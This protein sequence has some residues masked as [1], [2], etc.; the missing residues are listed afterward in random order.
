MKKGII[1][2]LLMAGTLLFANGAEESPAGEE[3]LKIGISQ[4][5]Q[6]PALDAVYQGIVDEMA[7]LGYEDVV[8]DYQ[9]SNADV[10]TA[11]Q[12]ANLYQSKKMDMVVGIA[13]PNAQ[14]LKMGVTNAPVIYSAIT[15]PVSA[16]LVDSLE[17]GEPGINGTSFKNPFKEQI[18]F[19]QTLK[20]VKVLGQVYTGNE[21]NAMFQ[22]EQ[23]RLACEELGIEYIGTSITSSAEVKSA[24]ETLINRVD[25]LFV[26]TDSTVVS[27]LSGLAD[28][29]LNHQVPVISADT[30]SAK[31]NPVLVAWGFD[32]YYIGQETARLMDKILQG[33]KAENLP[34]TVIS[35]PSHMEMVI[36]TAVADQIGLDLPASVLEQADLI[37]AE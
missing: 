17:Q 5:V 22:A 15:D 27:A 16:G 34:T 19:L 33:E 7:A 13:T 25:A 6:H 26:T 2:A 30:A 32:W 1:P 31:E 12:I 10:N 3:P 35:D 11:R 9:N 14:A 8:Y 28:T 18:Q 23:V 37:I 36:N 29:A 20:D 21:D 4:F 24:A